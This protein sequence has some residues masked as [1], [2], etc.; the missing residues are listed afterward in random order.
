MRW[1]SIILCLNVLP[2]LSQTDTLRA[3]KGLQARLHYGFI[4]AHSE[5]VQN[6][7]GAHPRG[8]EIEYVKQ[9]VDT[10]TWDNCRCYPTTGLSLSYFNYN[11]PILGH[12]VT[13]SYFLE[14]AYRIGRKGQF[15]F[16]GGIGLSYLTD[17]YDAHFNPTNMSYSTKLGGYLQLGVGAGL[18]VAPQWL[19]QAAV[20]YQH[21]SNGGV[22][23]PNK[24]INWPTASVGATWQRQ[25]YQ[26]PFYRRRNLNQLINNQ[27]YV[28]ATVWLSAKQG[29]QQG[30]GTA[31]T[32]LG[33]VNLQVS[34][35]V[36]RTSAL[37]SAIELSFDNALYQRLVHDS[38]AGSAVR[39][40][41]LFGHEFLLGR[42]FLSQQLGV[43]AFSRSPYYN[44]L[45]HRWALRYRVNEHWLLGFGLKAHRQV[46]DFIDLRLSYRF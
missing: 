45:C 39:A 27:P 18:Q 9:K 5:H 40:G 15:R 29:R 44:R 13:V 17:P 25:P 8:I 22:K 43:Y 42:F 1:L 28:E 41:V 26:L 30:G 12:S 46:A 7:A 10:T 6:T 35:Q 3:Y 37:N 20:N 32:A 2:V 14:P 23:E 16:R 24:G 4:F 33:G 36:G 38:V 11:T 31:R 19:L 34:K 21:I